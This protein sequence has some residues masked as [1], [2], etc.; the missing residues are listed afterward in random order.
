MLKLRELER[1]DLKTIN[2]WRNNPYLISFLGAPFRFINNEVDEKWFDNYMANRAVNVRCAIV[3]DSDNIIKGLVSLNSID[4]LNQS[5][6]LNI[7]IGDEDNCGKGIGTFAVN[8]ILKHA[9]ENMNLRRIYL[10]ALEDNSRARHLYEKLGFVQEGVLRESNFK[11]GKF[12]NMVMYSI[13]R[14]EFYL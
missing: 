13:L 9:F 2:K 1:D 5:A 11:N 3:D 7:M 10:T 8:V 12:I 4:Y 14:E 6:E